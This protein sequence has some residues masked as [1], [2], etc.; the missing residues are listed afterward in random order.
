MNKS[1]NFG[2][3]DPKKTLPPDIAIESAG[4][5]L[6]LIGLSRFQFGSKRRNKFHNPLFSLVLHIVFLIRC[7]LLIVL[8][9]EEAK[10]FATISGDYSHFFRVRKHYNIGMSTFLLLPIINQI[11]YYYNYYYNIYPIYL[12]PFQM[13]SGLVSPQSIG[14]LEQISVNKLLKRAKFLFF[15]NKINSILF[16]VFIT[17]IPS[18]ITYYSRSLFEILFYGIPWTLL[19]CLCI[20]FT[21]EYLIWQISYFYLDCFYLRLKLKSIKSKIKCG[22]SLN[23]LVRTDIKICPILKSLH[24]AFIEIYNFNNN[25]WS[26]YLLF[27]IVIFITSLNISIYVSIFAEMHFY[28]RLLF[29]YAS[30]MCGMTYLMVINSASSVTHAVDQFYGLLNKLLIHSYSIQIFER[31]KVLKMIEGTII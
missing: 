13:M 31:I 19:F 23:H 25:F 7:I 28:L 21:F 16:A 10:Q 8:P 11:I 18:F 4:S 5:H 27:F 1:Q 9:E 12:K 26:K 30:I 15:I 2:T 24:E 20:Y 17:I 14:I 3:F 22:L 29:I 6:Y